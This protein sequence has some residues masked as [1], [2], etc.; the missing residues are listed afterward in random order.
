MLSTGA[1]PAQRERS[2]QDARNR[3]AAQRAPLERLAGRFRG[4]LRVDR[5]QHFAGAGAQQPDPELSSRTRSRRHREAS[6]AGFY[7]RRL[8]RGG[9]GATE[10]RVL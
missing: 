4:V 10:R 9:E 1:R 7:G 8:A 3:V 6:P 5:G 2:V